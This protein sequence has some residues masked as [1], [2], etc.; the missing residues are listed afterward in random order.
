[1]A[2]EQRLSPTGQSVDLDEKGTSG[3]D[4][5]GASVMLRRWRQYLDEF[6]PDGVSLRMLLKMRHDPAIAL[7]LHMIQAPL[8]RA[9]WD[10]V[11]QDPV[12][13][14]FLKQAVLDIYPE[15]MLYSMSSIALGFGAMTKQFAFKVP[16]TESGDLTWDRTDVLPV[17]IKK[18]RQLDPETVCPKVEQD[19]FRGIEQ[20][21]GPDIDLQYCLWVTHGKE[22][23]F[24]N[25]YGWGLPRNVYHLWWSRNYRYALKDRHIEDRVS[26]PVVVRHPPG[27]VEDQ[28]TGERIYYRDAAIAVGKAIRSGET[29]A[30]SSE[31]YIGE[32]GDQK[33]ALK[34]DVKYLTG[35]ENV[36]AF[37][38]LDE[39]DDARTLMGLLIPPQSLLSAQGGLGSQAVAE[40]LGEMFWISQA[41]RKDALDLQINRY[42]VDQ[43]DALNFPPYSPRARLVTTGFEKQDLALMDDVLRTLA[44]RPDV[45]EFVQA[46][47]TRT[48][49]KERG[50]P[51]RRVEA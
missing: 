26:P 4:P 5:F 32:L 19:E 38:R 31:Q 14:R 47:D 33:G 16:V 17:V 28:E 35:G 34:W 23:V 22:L 3:K 12:K 37:I 6:D 8:I 2:Q 25:L 29:V 49:M 1:M 18:L 40:T 50:L 11:C 9:Q 10:I 46:F 42:V 39:Q 27:Y 15:L 13:K 51:V 36:D 20:S 24:G 45:Q 48:A 30:M 41:I 7:G 43:L 21:G 44:G